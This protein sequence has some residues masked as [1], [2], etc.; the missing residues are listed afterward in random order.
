[1]KGLTVFRAITASLALALALGPVAASAAYPEKSVTYIV[2]YNP[3]GESDVTARLQEPG[4]KQLT[5]KSF[6]FQYK[7]GAGGATAW[8]QLNQLPADGYTI[9]GFNLPHLFLQPMGGDVGYKT[10]DI[11][12]VYIF[13]L[14][15]HALIV[16]ADSPIKSLDD[17]IA[18][19]KQAP[20]TIT[21]AG[22]GTNSAPHVAKETFDQG[23]G[24]KTTYIPFTGT[25]ASTAALLGNQVQAQWAFITVGVEQRE[26]VRVLGVAMDERHP[27]FPDVPTF[28]EKGI[29][30]VDGARRG[31]AVP[32][33]TP[34][35]IK[36]QLSDI[37][38]KINQDPDFRK[39]MRDGGY[40]L[41]DVPYKDV[42]Q[43]MD[44]L[45]KQYREAGRLLG[46]VK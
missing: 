5:G 26:K 37:F 32:A 40:L 16:P 30:L 27:L 31:V 6:V 15:P 22:V 43:Y 17:Y 29:D 41:V 28:K 34:E 10:D 35:E 21:V 12:I 45:G 1:M 4:F 44:R 39:T 14:T 19:A 2:P 36:Q 13:Q 20:G 7:P 33:G 9:V 18:Q 24:I 8:S 11:K 23:A 25:S 3:G 46:L 42:P 38:A